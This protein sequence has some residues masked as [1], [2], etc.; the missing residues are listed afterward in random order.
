VLQWIPEIPIEY[1]RFQRLLYNPMFHQKMSTPWNYED[2]QYL[3][4]WYYIIGPEEMSYAL[5]RTIKSIMQRVVKLKKEGIMEKQLCRTY[6]KKIKKN[7]LQRVQ[8]K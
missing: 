6:S 5:D 4:N 8:S 1:D 2:E 7:P 3:I